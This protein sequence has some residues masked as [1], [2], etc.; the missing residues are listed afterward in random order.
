MA[1]AIKLQNLFR[2]R[3]ARETREELLA[4]TDAGKTAHEYFMARD[5]QTDQ[6]DDFNAYGASAGAAEIIRRSEEEE[7]INREL[8]VMREKVR[9]Q[10]LQLSFFCN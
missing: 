2:A 1:A 8:A 7:K 6:G 5:S 4:W 10:N 3:K 9:K